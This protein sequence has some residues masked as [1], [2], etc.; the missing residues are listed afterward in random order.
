M[1]AALAQYSVAP[2]DGE[3]VPYSVP[4]VAVSKSGKKLVCS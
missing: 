3:K 2:G 4:L 1:A